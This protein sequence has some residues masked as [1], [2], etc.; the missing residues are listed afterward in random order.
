MNIPYEVCASADLIRLP[1]SAPSGAARGNT[2]WSEGRPEQIAAVELFLAVEETGTYTISWISV[3]LI[4][5][6]RKK[7]PKNGSAR[8]NV[9]THNRIQTIVWTR[10]SPKLS[11]LTKR[12]FIHFSLRIAIEMDQ[13]PH[14]ID[15]VDA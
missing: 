4:T 11:V 7:Y 14:G 13:G 3:L 15:S 1:D 12:Y 8:P 5:S 6:F 9:R 10:T 2:A